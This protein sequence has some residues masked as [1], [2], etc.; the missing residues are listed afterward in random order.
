MIYNLHLS[1][2]FFNFFRGRP[3][4][5]EISFSVSINFSIKIS[6]ATSYLKAA[7]EFIGL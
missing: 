4:N 3:I 1:K 5:P 6:F 7:E 2:I